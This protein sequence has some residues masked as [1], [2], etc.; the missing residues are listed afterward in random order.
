[1]KILVVSDAHG[2]SENLREALEIEKPDRMYYLGDGEGLEDRFP[3]MTQ[4]P[5]ECVQGNCDIGTNLPREVVLTVGKHV[6]LLTH[7][8]F[9]GVNFGY[10]KIMEAAEEKGCDVILYGHTHVPEIEY[11]ATKSGRAVTIA[12]PGSI[13]YPRQKSREHTYLVIEVDPD[14]EFKYFLHSLEE[15]DRLNG[16]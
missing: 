15:H 2:K 1:M 9:Y 6:V 10:G 3:V 8:H 4:V 5:V 11:R 13:A 12:N 16:N 14:G 7:G